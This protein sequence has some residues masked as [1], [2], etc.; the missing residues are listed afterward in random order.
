MF[1]NL[2]GFKAAREPMGDR[3]Q[4]HSARDL[5]DLRPWQARRSTRPRSP[6]AQHDHLLSLKIAPLK[7]RDRAG[8]KETTTK[9]YCAVLP[10]WA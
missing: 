4:A 5:S 2:K 8:A 6:R 10:S 3:K 7:G 1:H 9:M